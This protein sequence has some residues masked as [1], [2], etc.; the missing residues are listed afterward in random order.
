M[1]RIR[2]TATVLI[3]VSLLALTAC[4][5][6]DTDAKAGST[7]PA[8]ST[9]ATSAAA[10]SAPAPVNG[11]GDAKLC[12]E[13][14]ASAKAWNA[15]LTAVMKSAEGKETPVSEIQE[16]HADFASALNAVAG[17]GDSKAAAAAKEL[18]THVGKA[19][20]ATDPL[21]GSYTPGFEKSIKD[22]TAACKAAGVKFN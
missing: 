19:A 3:S 15:D 17:G 21:K 2:S 4:G 16:A 12:A 20:T 13:A 9:G 7:P 8:V 6:N 18:A 22:L 11:T 10:T 14:Q 1:K 5:G